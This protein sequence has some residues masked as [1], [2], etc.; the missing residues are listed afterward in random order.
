MFFKN[1]PQKPPFLLPLL[2]TIKIL[3]SYNKY[4]GNDTSAKLRISCPGVIMAAT[5]SMAKKAY[6][7]RE[8]FNPTQ[9][10]IRIFNPKK[11]SPFMYE[12]VL[13]T[14]LPRVNLCGI[15]KSAPQLR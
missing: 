12:P 9:L 4:K 6:L 11:D 15:R 13:T 8:T 5:V 3:S 1:N 7:S 14:C 2:R 10:S